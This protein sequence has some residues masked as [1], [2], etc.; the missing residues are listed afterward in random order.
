MKKPEGHVK[1]RDSLS[2]LM[3]LAAPDTAGVLLRCLLGSVRI[4]ASLLFVW[5]S[6]TLVDTATGQHDGP[7]ARYVAVMVGIM[8]LQCV[9]G[10]LASYVEGRMNVITIVRLRAMT[11]S[12]ILRS[13]WNGR[14][15]MH[16]GDAV[17]RMESDVTVLADLICSR[18]PDIIITVCQLIAASFYLLEMS[19]GLMWLLISLM[20][21][22]A[23]GSKL[24]FVRIRELTSAIR[25]KESQIQGYMQ[26]NLLHRAV[27]LTL[28]GID[29]VLEKLASHQND[30]VENTERRL[31][32]GIAGRGLLSLGFAA[33]YASAFFWGIFGIRS[34]AV[35]FG[36]MT[37]FLQLVGQVQSPIAGL[38][39]H[40]PAFI[41]ALT[42]VDRISEIM[43]LKEEHY[44]TPVH[45]AHLPGIEV[46]NVSFVYPDNSKKVLDGFSCVFR[47]GSFTAITGETGAGKSTLMR[48][49]LALL[50]PTEGEIVITDGDSEITV[51]TDTRCNFMYVPQGNTLM[52]GTIRD[53]FL[54][55]NPD[56]TEEEMTT[57]LK[58]AAADFI[59]EKPDGLDTVCS[60][61]GGG[62]S[63]GQAQRV[64]IARALLHTGS[65]LIMDESTSALDPATELHVLDR[66]RARCK[67]SKTVIFVSHRE[68]VSD[69]ADSVIR[70]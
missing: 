44:G 20:V 64:A 32:Y 6:K 29:G 43:G 8:L 65:I 24:Y 47:P 60:E 16:T 61:Q 37:A 2:A 49:L 62:L 57:A 42:S 66:L 23:A 51:S 58:D 55:A 68:T 40:I 1:F 12:R 41:H 26:E 35:T 11:F 34:G 30:V 9:T 14:E 19:P 53:N 31:R 48:L 36:T 10:L 15:Q 39:R 38:S 18:M 28:A 56:A 3:K 7:L 33:G 59:L 67:G 25:K 52:S 46:R 4:V 17:N 50:H 13:E 54:M 21:L 5:I 45:A 63:E 69:W 27:A 70:F 22:A